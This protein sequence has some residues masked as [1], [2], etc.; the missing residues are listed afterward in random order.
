M[1]RLACKE[2]FG[3]V[4]GSEIIE[5]VERTTGEACPCKQGFV[6]PLLPPVAVVAE[7]AA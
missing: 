7:P 5:L 2:M 6:C 1:A 4:R 3:E